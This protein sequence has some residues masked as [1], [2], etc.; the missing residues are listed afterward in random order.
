MTTNVFQQITD[1][2]VAADCHQIHAVYAGIGS[3][4]TPHDVLYLMT[5]IATKLDVWGWTVRSGGADGADTAFEGA[6]RKEIYLPWSGFNGKRGSTPS[7]EAY[8]I[9]ETHHP[10]WHALERSV[11]SLHARNAHQILGADCATP[12][13]FVITW[14]PDG[15]TGI[16]TVKT[17]GTGQAIRIA[18]AYDVSI[19]NL[20]RDDHRA[21]WEE[22]IR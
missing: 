19:F 12:A 7:A 4:T 17:G 1:I 2:L 11:R 13:A 6:S 8:T 18:R 15:S 10:R 5:S 9:A 16:T 20:H 22:A 3:R 21:A 14:T